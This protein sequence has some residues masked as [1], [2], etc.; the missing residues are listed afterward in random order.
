MS[1]IGQVNNLKP[2]EIDDVITTFDKNS[3]EKEKKVDTETKKE[4]VVKEV[5]KVEQVFIDM[6]PDK[7]SP[8][9]TAYAADN[10]IVRRDIAQAAEKA[11]AEQKNKK[12][13]DTPLDDLV[14]PEVVFS[15]LPRPSLVAF[16]DGFSSLSS[17]VKL[18]QTPYS[19]DFDDTTNVLTIAGGGGA[20]SAA[21]NGNRETQVEPELLDLSEYVG[22][23]T[24][25]TDNTNYFGDN[26]ITRVISFEA[27]MPLQYYLTDLTI[28]GIPSGF[29][30]AQVI[31]LLMVI[32][33]FQ[34]HSLYQGMF[35]SYC[36]M[37]Q[38]DLVVLHLILMGMVLPMN[39]Q[40]LI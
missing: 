20:L 31:R 17:R 35:N 32:M 11:K 27:L 6:N 18:L 2:H 25:F 37:I 33:S 28:S 40:I 23:T 13:Y 36:N 10:Q 7:A 34:G 5:V 19:L 26:L 30:I 29:S 38:V 14:P 21:L 8:T 9:T 24:I 15:S 4:V 1:K 39:M 3:G 22:E 16:G 12:K